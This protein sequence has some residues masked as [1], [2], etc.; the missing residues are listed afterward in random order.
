MSGFRKLLYLRELRKNA[1]LKGE[2][3]AKIQEKKLRMIIKHSYENVEYYHRKM[4]SLS[5]KPEDIKNASDLKKLPP[6]SKEEVRKNSAEGM[7]ARN[8]NVAKCKKYS[9][10]GSTGIPLTVLVD[11]EANDYRAALFGRAFLECGL[12]LMDRMMMVGDARHFHAKERYWFQKL[13]ILRRKYFSAA[14]SVE[15][16]L[17]GI[18]HY[19]PDAIFAYSSYLF[20]LAKAIQREAIKGFHPRL[21]FSTA[22]VLGDEER[23]FI[24]SVFGTETFDLYGCVETERLAWECEEHDQYHMDIDSAVIE[25]VKENEDVSPGEEGKMLVT[26][27]YNHAMPLIRYDLGDIGIPSNETCPCGRGLPL[28]KRILGRKDDFIICPNGNTVYSIPIR[29]AIRSVPGIAQY[30]VVQQTE[31][32]LNVFIVQEDEISDVAVERMIDELRKVVGEEMT[33]LPV[34]VDKIEKE[35]SG[36]I[37]AVLSHVRRPET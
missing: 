12:R 35:T 11:P 9:T 33:I 24:N 26:C 3:L 15:Q 10:S 30:R 16:Q 27:L 29:H 25:F 2:Q 20:L 32:K 5:L 13:G 21:V 23:T 18:I 22:E 4:D 31:R 7:I 6:V 19:N 17:P 37:R 8:I 14:D 1:R 36:K 34:F 28:M